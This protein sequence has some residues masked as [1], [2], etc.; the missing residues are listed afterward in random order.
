MSTLSRRAFSLL[1]PIVFSFALRF[2]APGDVPSVDY[3]HPHQRVELEV[4]GGVNLAGGE[5]GG[6]R[7][8]TMSPRIRASHSSTLPSVSR[9]FLTSSKALWRCMSMASRRLFVMDEV[10]VN[11]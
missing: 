3:T 6:H 5:E 7:R 8:L 11:T 1:L 4:G 10:H 2:M 9:F